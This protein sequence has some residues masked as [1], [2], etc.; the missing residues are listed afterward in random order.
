MAKRNNP[1]CACCG[2]PCSACAG[3]LPATIH[4]ADGLGNTIPLVFHAAGASTQDWSNGFAGWTAT[5]TYSTARW[6]TSTSG[7]FCQ[8]TGSPASGTVTL[9]LAI[10]CT[11][12]AI[13][14]TVYSNQCPDATLG[15]NGFYDG[16]VTT[17]KG[18]PAF[19]VTGSGTTRLT[20][21][22]S[23]L[24][25][26]YKYAGIGSDPIKLIFTSTTTLT[27]TS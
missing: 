24:N 15:T 5:Q 2:I 21:A 1:G 11:G 16:G 19:N 26:T 23:P 17:P 14:L 22:C 3:G 18:G 9:G 7:G 6:Y 8:P 20:Q 10:R 13:V 12:A 25:A 27:L 4:L